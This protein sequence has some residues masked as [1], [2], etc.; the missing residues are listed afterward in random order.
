MDGDRSEVFVFR[1]IEAIEQAI[2]V[3]IEIRK[4]KEADLRVRKEQK[5]AEKKLK[6]GLDQISHDI[7]TNGRPPKVQK[8]DDDGSYVYH[9]N[10]NYNILFLTYSTCCY[11]PNLKFS[12]YNYSYDHHRLILYFS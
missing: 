5:E 9:I 11:G 1:E 4:D 3:A 10:K 2:N 6:E 12:N 7:A 8:L